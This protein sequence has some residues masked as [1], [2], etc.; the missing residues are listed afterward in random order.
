[1]VI[2]RRHCDAVVPGLTDLARIK[3]VDDAER[4]ILQRRMAISECERNIETARAESR[5]AFLRHRIMLA[6]HEAA[7]VFFAS[8]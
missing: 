2:R 8:L 5:I 4:Y 3:T 6:L 1:M 7:A